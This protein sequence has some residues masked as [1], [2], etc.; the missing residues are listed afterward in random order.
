M[1]EKQGMTIEQTIQALKDEISRLKKQ[2]S[3]DNGDIVL[4]AGGAFRFEVSRV[5]KDGSVFAKRLGGA[6]PI[7]KKFRKND[8]VIIKKGGEH[9][10]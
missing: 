6:Y 3:P 1:A 2:N 10:E 9:H 5:E 7:Y 4:D 8:Y